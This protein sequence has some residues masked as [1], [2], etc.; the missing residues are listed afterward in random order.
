MITVSRRGGPQ[1]LFFMHGMESLLN[2]PFRG[3]M[4]T[5]LNYYMG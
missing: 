1:F 4:T 5:R 3:G 2:L